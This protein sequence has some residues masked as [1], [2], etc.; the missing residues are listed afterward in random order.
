MRGLRWVALAL[1]TI[2]G[3][4]A[5]VGGGKGATGRARGELAPDELL[6]VTSA[7]ASRHLTF[8]SR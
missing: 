5:T 6:A 4:A 3:C 1:V 7:H 2:T 8:T